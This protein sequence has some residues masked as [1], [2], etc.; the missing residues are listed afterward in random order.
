MTCKMMIKYA[1]VFGEVLK[2]GDAKIEKKR[3][4]KKKKN[5]ILIV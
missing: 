1:T 3:K 4:Q 5:F 2:N